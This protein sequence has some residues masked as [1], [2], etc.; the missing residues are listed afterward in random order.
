MRKFVRFYRAPKWDR[1]QQQLYRE[2][3][4]LLKNTSLQS[5]LRQQRELPRFPSGPS[6]CV[7]MRVRHAL[8]LSPFGIIIL[9]SLLELMTLSH[10]QNTLIKSVNFENI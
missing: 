2:T 9:A 5:S 10:T 7:R 1:Y 6:K 4:E 8:S 3:Y